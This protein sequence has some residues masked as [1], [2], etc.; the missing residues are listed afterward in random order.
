LFI[1]FLGYTNSVKAKQKGKNGILWAFLTIISYII[2]EGIGLYFVIL[3]FCQGQVD[4]GAL[5][6]AT[7]A[8]SAALTQRFE[9]QVTAAFTANPMRDM[10]VLLFGLGGFLLI[11]YILD[12]TPDKKQPEI[13]WMD[14]MGE[15][16]PEN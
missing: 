10:L 5:M 4:I 12:R 16:G 14:K 1:C 11:R 13:H 6:H 2:L 8:N 9:D 15:K 3:V 7:P